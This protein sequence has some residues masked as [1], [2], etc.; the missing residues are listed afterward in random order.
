MNE[1]EI[2][3]KHMAELGKKAQAKRT[4]EQR[5]AI[6]KKGWETRRAKKASSNK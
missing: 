5:K 6:A 2:I 4:L 1:K 3:S